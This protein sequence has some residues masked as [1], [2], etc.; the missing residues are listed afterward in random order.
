L[1][2]LLAEAR[3]RGPLAELHPADGLG[4]EVVTSSE[5]LP[6]QDDPVAVRSHCH[7]FEFA[8]VGSDSEEV[9]V[10]PV[11]GQSQATHRST[12]PRPVRL[13]AVGEELYPHLEGRPLQIRPVAQESQDGVRGAGQILGQRRHGLA[14]VG[15]VEQ[16]VY[17]NWGDNAQPVD[18]SPFDVGEPDRAFRLTAGIH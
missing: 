13:G 8:L 6:A 17:R 7:L 9:E 1:G 5:V 18:A 14:E 16:G 12:L 10:I 2:E 15:G 4:L 3:P 11:P